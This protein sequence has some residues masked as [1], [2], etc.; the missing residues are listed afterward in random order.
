M[1]LRQNLPLAIAGI[2]VMFAAWS[3][4]KDN[5]SKSTTSTAPANTIQL[6]V[7]TKFGSVMT[8]DKGKTLYFF[9]IDANGTSGCSGG[10]TTA[11]PTFYQPNLTLDKGLD[12][13]D[14]G[15]I[16][17]ASDG[18]KQTTYKGWPL[19]YFSGD[20]KAGDTNG[21]GLESIWF[22]AK[23]D[24]T[25]MVTNSQLLG[26]DNVNYDHLLK[27]GNEVTQYI[28]D[29]RGQ[30]LYSFSHDKSKT[31]TF[32]VPD[33]SNNKVWPIDTVKTVLNVP[34]I[35][36]KTQFAIITVFG[37][38]QLSYKG[39]PLYYFGQDNNTRGSNKG[40]AFPKPGIWPY[41]NS[42]SPVAPN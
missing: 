7:N 9:A 23:P 32:T 35:L 21:D 14:F 33:F 24:Y 30:T 34:S 11:W 20:A 8:D 16:T 5:N 41:T 29:D 1:K 15:T 17:R 3:C 31:N 28:T 19:Y 6:A 22:V 26:V 36:D 37:K 12:A 39:W 10:C 4:K 18:A 40:I 42:S 38:S 2:A 27:P 25:V 13:K